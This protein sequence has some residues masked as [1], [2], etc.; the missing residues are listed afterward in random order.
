MRSKIWILLV[1]VHC[2]AFAASAQQ[3]PAKRQLVL[4]LSNGGFVGFRSETSSPAS[5]TL[6]N[7]NA[8]AALL[9]SRAFAG[10]NRIIHRVLTDAQQNVVFGYD[11]SITA[12]PVTKKLRKRF[13]IYPEALDANVQFAKELERTHTDLLKRIQAERQQNH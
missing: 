9:Y 5:T 13:D 11:L 4:Q 1:C 8:L 12:D 10:D 2:L 7:A 3:S 6:P